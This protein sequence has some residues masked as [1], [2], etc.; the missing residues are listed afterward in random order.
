MDPRGCLRMCLVPLTDD[1][2]QD[3]SANCVTVRV[4]G[5]GGA[6]THLGRTAPASRAPE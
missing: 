1:P 4:I 3:R 2:V 5:F 6:G